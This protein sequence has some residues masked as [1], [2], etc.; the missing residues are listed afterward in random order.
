M[1]SIPPF[2]A[3]QKTILITGCSSGIGRCAA[4]A[5]HRLG[6]QVIASVRQEKD[7]SDF[8]ERGIPCVQLDL[9]D[10]ESI[11]RA[12]AQ[13]LTITNGKLFALFNNGAYGQT[14]ALEDLPTQALIEQFHTN[15]FGWH[16]LTKQV[17]PIM[18]AQGEG[19]IIQCSS[20]LGIVAM[21]YRGA[22]NA[23][24]FALEGYTDTLR[25]ELSDTPIQ[26]SLIEPGPIETAFRAN[27]LAKFQQWIQP[28]ISR[29]QQAYQLQIDRLSQSQSKSKFCLPPESCLPPLCHALSAKQSKARYRVTQPTKLF[30]FFKRILSTKQLDKLLKRGV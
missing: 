28:A 4:F 2:A 22:Y 16:H 23:S 26:V 30:A 20:V 9:A 13:V 15:L 21:K 14:G 25:L 29:H 8:Y 10:L 1:S 12:I 27:A 24:K 3:A 11:D 5:M 19:R 17:I 7:M 18:R 6:M